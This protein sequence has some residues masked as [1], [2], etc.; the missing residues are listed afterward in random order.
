[1][2]MKKDNINMYLYGTF[3]NYKKHNKRYQ[4]DTY[5]SLIYIY[6]NNSLI[7]ADIFG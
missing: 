5:F 6:N 4:L 1:M 3:T 2:T 7:I